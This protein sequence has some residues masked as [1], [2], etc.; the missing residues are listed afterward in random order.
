MEVPLTPDSTDFEDDA[1][2]HASTVKVQ[3]C[4]HDAAW[5]LRS[6]ESIAWHCKALKVLAT[7]RALTN[8]ATMSRL[9]PLWLL[10][11]KLLV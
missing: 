11:V 5:L 4:T 2:L 3:Y 8:A 6:R 9:S 1:A 7:G 10:R